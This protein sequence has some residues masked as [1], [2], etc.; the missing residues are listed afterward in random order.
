MPSRKEGFVIA[1]LLS[2][3]WAGLRAWHFVGLNDLDA[4]ILLPL[5]LLLVYVRRD[6]QWNVWRTLLRL[7]NRLDREGRSDLACHDKVHLFGDSESH[8]RVTLADDEN[9]VC[10]GQAE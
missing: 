6:N 3:L 1:V 4:E 8:G 5:I 10:R 7:E 2:S 9:D